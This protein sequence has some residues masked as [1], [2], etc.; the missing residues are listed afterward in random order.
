MMATSNT[1]TD[2]NSALGITIPVLGA[3]VLYLVAS[4]VDKRDDS[5]DEK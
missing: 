3:G 1:A 5:A 2:G 4:F